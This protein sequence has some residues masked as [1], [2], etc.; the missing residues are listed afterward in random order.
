L[1]VNRVGNNRLGMCCRLALS[2]AKPN[3]RDLWLP[4]QDELWPYKIKNR[5]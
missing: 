2:A 4:K 5:I 3:K 1:I